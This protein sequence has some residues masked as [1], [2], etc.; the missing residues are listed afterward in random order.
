MCTAQAGLNL[1]SF[2]PLPPECWYYRRVPPRPALLI[3][4]RA[5]GPLVSRDAPAGLTPVSLHREGQ[6]CRLAT[7]FGQPWPQGLGNGSFPTRPAKQFSTRRAG[8]RSSSTAG[9]AQAKCTAPPACDGTAAG[10]IPAGQPGILASTAYPPTT[11]LGRKRRNHH[12]QK[13]LSSLL[14][15]G[16]AR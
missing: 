3:D 8:S 12:H 11:P 15:N 2:L 16:S 5:R 7:A 1:A 9:K 14:T 4:L 10:G 6:V 13:L